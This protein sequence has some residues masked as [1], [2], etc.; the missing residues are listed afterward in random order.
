MG[1]AG[2]HTT[3]R[4]ESYAKNSHGAKQAA[5]KDLDGKRS[6]PG[7]PLAD[8]LEACTADGKSGAVSGQLR[9]KDRHWHALFVAYSSKILAPASH[10][11]AKVSTAPAT[12]AVPA[13][14]PAIKPPT[15]R[16]GAPS[17]NSI[18]NQ[19]LQPSG[20]RNTMI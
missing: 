3:L 12:R 2:D 6:T 8:G 13:A 11:S 20:G 9:L 16:L 4:P 18:Y 19:T 7:G 1:I 15:M 10:G 5:P 14:N 17:S